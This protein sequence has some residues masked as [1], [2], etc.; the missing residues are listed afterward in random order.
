MGLYHKKSKNS[1]QYGLHEIPLE[2]LLPEYP[3]DQLPP[4]INGSIE[5]GSVDIQIPNDVVGLII[6]KQASNVKALKDKTRCDIRVQR[7]EDCDQ[8]LETR[9]C[10]LKGS[11]LCIVGRKITLRHQS[12]IKLQPRISESSKRP[13]TSKLPLA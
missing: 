9:Y 5:S 1:M 2:P 3:E 8:T 11:V 7:D 10:S 12:T 6:G 13:N 4:I